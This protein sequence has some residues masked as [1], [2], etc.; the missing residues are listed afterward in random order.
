M[1]Y[2]LLT[3]ENVMT[4]ARL[5]LLVLA[6]IISFSFCFTS[7]QKNKRKEEALKIVREWTGKEIKFP[8][9]LNFIS[10]ANDTTCV[11]VQNDNFKILLY[12]D[13][14]GCTSCRFNLSEWKKI[15]QESDTA[16]IR[17]PEFIF[18]F[19]TKTGDE[20]ELQS[21]L[22]KN[23]FLHPVLIDKNNEIEKINKFPSNPEYQCFLLN[24]D[25]KVLLIGNP[26]LV[27]GIWILY[28]RVITERTERENSILTMEK[29]E[30]LVDGDKTS[31]LTSDF[32]LIRKEATKK[33]KLI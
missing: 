28:K 14:L 1:G 4:E 17:K 32:P 31:T 33:T 8:K 16:L 5:K 3:K 20:K 18:I 23:R 2:R 10:M 15:M 19:Q 30:E 22:R 6:G 11:D 24:K 26:S 7:C 12:V 25:N 27:S 13:S 21:L 9:E 29:C